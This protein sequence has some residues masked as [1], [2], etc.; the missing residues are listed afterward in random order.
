M[1]G[2]RF[3]SSWSHYHLPHCTKHRRST[4][5]VNL[6]VI[7]PESSR[8]SNI[9]ITPM[10]QDTMSNIFKFPLIPSFIKSL[11]KALPTLS[12][13]NLVSI[14]ALEMTN[15]KALQIH[16]LYSKLF[17]SPAQRFCSPFNYCHST[18]LVALPFKRNT[19]HSFNNFRV[20]EERLCK[21][22]KRKVL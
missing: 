14:H 18:L 17:S 5:R 3:S 10:K 15:Q 22:S 7:E 2:A 8:Y 9:T 11:L 20:L 21:G 19:R 1:P 16:S 6:S 13:N 12:E 4:V